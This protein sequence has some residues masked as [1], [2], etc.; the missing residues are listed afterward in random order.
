[1]LAYTLAQLANALLFTGLI[2]AS[3]FLNDDDETGTETT[4]ETPE[5]TDGIPDY[6]TG[7]EGDNFLT[8]TD[9]DGAN[10]TAGDGNDSILGTDGD[11]TL[12]AGKGDDTADMGAGND[13]VLAKAG[14]DVIAGGDGNDVLFGGTGADSLFGDA[15]DDSLTGGDED[16]AL[17][18]GDDADFL[19]GGADDDALFGDAGDDVL[20]GSAGNDELF[21]GAGADTLNGAFGDASTLED[22][23]I[24]G[25][26]NL[27]GGAGSDTLILGAGDQGTGGAGADTFTVD[28]AVADQGTTEITDFDATEDLLQIEFTTTTDPETG[29]PVEPA[30]SVINFDDGTGASIVLNGVTVAKV[31]GAFDLDPALI[32]LIAV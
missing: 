20:W 12:Q 26:D 29:D 18:G 16:D 1:M 13:R 11:D 10:F 27:F 19:D 21:G 7:D 3:F 15:G 22:G 14:D 6:V 24:D 17:Y 31:S 32:T 5:V 9:P 25:A 4:S 30:L 2:G 23:S 28:Q 8:S